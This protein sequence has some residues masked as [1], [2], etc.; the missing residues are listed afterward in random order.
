MDA[1]L[2]RTLGMLLAVAIGIKAFFERGRR[3]KDGENRL[4]KFSL[5]RS[6]HVLVF[7]HEPACEGFVDGLEF[8]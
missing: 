4:L 2:D 1:N 5:G 3:R 7:N 6:W 8:W